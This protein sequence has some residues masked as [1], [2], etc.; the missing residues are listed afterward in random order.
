MFQNVSYYQPKSH[1]L[2]VLTSQSIV[3]LIH[4]YAVLHKFFFKFT[5]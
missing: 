3:N 4:N 5:G 2:Y 1:A